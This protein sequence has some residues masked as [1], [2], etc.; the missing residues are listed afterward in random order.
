MGLVEAS[1]LRAR[2]PRT[3]WK[4]TALGILARYEHRLRRCDGLA[5]EV[6]SWDRSDR[7]DDDLG[8][9][10]RLLLDA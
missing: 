7:G 5:R 9:S 2:H 1:G 3:C 4:E 10:A 6:T 8:R